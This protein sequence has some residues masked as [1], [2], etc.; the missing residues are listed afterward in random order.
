MRKS[1][2]IFFVNLGCPKNLVETELMA[3]NLLTSGY[4]LV[5]DENDA[6]IVIINTCCF[7]PEART[8]TFNC[9]NGYAI[10]KK[11]H[12][13]R[14]IVVAGCLT[15]WMSLPE[16]R[17]KF[18]HVDVWAGGNAGRHLAE[19]IAGQ[20]PEGATGCASS[21][22]YDHTV[23]RLQ[24]TLPHVAYLKIADGCDNRCSYCAIPGIRGGLVSRTSDSV[25]QE[26][27]MLVNNGVRELV[28]IAQ[29]ITAFGMDRT[30]KTGELSGLLRQLDRLDT[31]NDFKI[32][33]LYTHP[34]HYNDELIETIAAGRRILHY[35]D[36][37]LQH[38]DDT[39]L[40]RMGRKITAAGVDEL[41]NKLRKAMPD[42]TLRTTFITGFPGEGEKEYEN[43]KNF[44]KKQRFDRMGV[45]AYSPEVRTPAAGF[46]DQVPESIA[47]A[48]TDELNLLQKDIMT[49]AMD[50]AKNSVFDAIIDSCRGS[51]AIGRG[52]A[53]APDIDTIIHI[54]CHGKKPRPGDFVRVRVTGRKGLEF[55][56][57][58]EEK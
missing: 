15:E 35:L 25:L 49:A 24:M 41:L 22:L 32:R 4:T 28:L 11:A 56:A 36:I 52:P 54:T 39:I 47:L 34:A 27:A 58:T 12:R 37:P 10:W 6:N 16:L 30:G 38:I 7:L 13:N 19:I 17:A 31:T 18:P 2:K 3:G 42:L 53:D 26:A 45:F 21:F 51:F 9:L 29:D 14:K 55:T 44:I 40:A 57:V 5:A 8:E 23:P 43:L 46:P 33:L 50:K 48:R 1:Q 20:I